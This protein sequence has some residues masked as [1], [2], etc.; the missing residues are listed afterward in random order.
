M[1][2]VKVKTVALAIRRIRPPDVGT[3]L[4]VDA[5]PFQVLEQLSLKALFAA[6]DIRVFDAQHHD[7]ALL[8]CEQP[9]EERGAG[10]ADMQ[11]PRR[12]RSETNANLGRVTHSMM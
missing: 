8:P 10:V 6:L 7:T 11:L 12:G 4:P 1:L 9:V 2:A 3:F 5:E